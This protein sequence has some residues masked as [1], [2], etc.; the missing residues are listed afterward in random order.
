[1]QWNCQGLRAK[2]EEL[3]MLINEFSPICIS[4]QESMMGN[5]VAPCPTEYISYDMPYHQNRGNHGGVLLYIR[6]DVPQ[7]GFILQSPL[8][9]IAAQIYLQRK[10]TVCSLYLPPNEPFSEDDLKSLIR[11]LP[12]PFLI[13][14]DFNG[15]N[16]LWGDLITNQRG[17]LISSVI[18]NES[19]GLLNTGEPTHFHIQTG[20]LSAIDLSLCS[21]NAIIDF[22]WKT[23]EDRYTSDHFPIIISIAQGP[24]AS[25][26]PKWN[27]DKADWGEFKKHCLIEATAEEFPSIDDAIELLNTTLYS[28]GLQ[29]IPRTS[30]IF[31]RKPVPW[32]SNECQ[33]A[34]RTMRAAFTRYRR[35]KCDFY[36]IEYRKSRAYFRLTVKKAR[37]GSW[38]NFISSINSKTPLS[39][40]WKKVR[41]IAGKYTP[42]QPPVL[43][44]NGVNVADPQVVADSFADHFANVSKKDEN[45][46]YANHRSQQEQQA[47]DFT[48]QRE[49][50][51][52]LPFNKEEFDSVLSRCNESA[53]GPD[54][55]PY[56]LIKQAPEDTKI[57]ILSILNRIYKEH[58]FPTV[59]ELAKILPF[60]KPAKD[61]SIAGNYRPIALTSCLCKIMEKMVNDRLVWYLER[62]KYLS[63]AQCGFR[64]MRSTSDVLIRLESS[65]CEAFASK[66][67]H[68]TIFFD[69]EKAYDTAWRYGILKIL[70]ECKLRGDLPLFIQAFLRERRFQVQIGSVLSVIMNQEEGVPQGSVLSVT[71]FALAINGLSKILPPEIM[72]TLFVDDFSMSYVASQMALAER[73]LQLAINKVV[74]W[75]EKNGFKFSTTKTVVVHFCRIRGCFLD[76][77]LYLNGQRIPCVRE[78][79]FL[80]LI[81]DNRLTWQP[82]L[83]DLKVKCLKALN[84]LKVLSHTS[85]GADRAQLLRLYKS[86]IFSKLMYGCEVYT[87]A[88]QNRLKVLNSI[89]H[90]GIRIA[91]G[92]FKSSP[93]ESLLVD[94]GEIS[95][96]LHFQNYLIRGWCRFQRLPNSLASIA[97]QNEMYFAYYENHPQLPRPFSFRVKK[98]CRN[99]NVVNDTVSPV[100]FSVVP[101]WKLPI[102]KSCNYFN[103]IKRELSD[104]VIHTMFLDHATQHANAV[105]IF[106]DGSRSDAGVGFGVVF[107]TFERSGRLPNSASIF[108]AE[109][110]GILAAV[111]ETLLIDENAF[112][113]YCDSKSVL[114]SLQQYNSV[115]PLVQDILEWLFLAKRRGRNI[116]FCWVPAHVGVL[117]NERADQLA[118]VAMSNPQPRRIP[119][120]HRDLFPLIKRRVRESWQNQ[121]ESLTET[122]KKMREINPSGLHLPYFNMPRRWET[123]LC[124][125]RIGHTLLTHEHLMANNYQRFCDDCIVPLTVQHLLTECPSFM[126]ERE[127]FLI[128]GK[129]RLGD[130]N[131]LEILGVGGDF[132]CKGL[133][134]FLIETNLLNKL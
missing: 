76:P 72:H 96:D 126:E 47:I 39:V 51:Y 44:I 68:V 14:G 34:H 48:T 124:R 110:H 93:I 57:F 7:N 40:V 116:E 70:Y 18:E 59:W 25:R 24:P 101:P 30:G 125:L 107:P 42:S 74:E 91:T 2:Y 41:K 21:E 92:A 81:W 13:L 113:I 99:L 129:D 79:R 36:L 97:I 102:I 56:A 82:Q 6:R 64:R 8:Q 63:P 87:S 90:A 29:T 49:E 98:I 17:N 75:A 60:A 22:E 55:I 11:Q 67:H 106:T 58:I 121:W 94:A 5:V 123:A 43:K 109:L 12:Q 112:V 127:R 105:P 15:R 28:A 95:L 77:D 61:T 118:R 23:I 66:K 119:I 45:K 73:R 83:T 84:V 50:V 33:V 80:G 32:W 103:F 53:P 37:K 54:D 62:E 85:W 114:D 31:R 16:P 108:T 88:T 35:R 132:T 122:N 38:S 130:F 89:H 20:T 3:K 117:G 26:T 128:Y 133:F 78:T 134:G 100:S 19:I 86:L 4:L 120:P 10:Y 46:P 1:M 9:A 27:I 69:I 52:N 115:H 65:I 104:D 71:L 131:L 111:K